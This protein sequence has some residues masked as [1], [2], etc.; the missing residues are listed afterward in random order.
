MQT[1]HDRSGLGFFLKK[2]LDCTTFV[3]VQTYLKL[4]GILGRI[5]FGSHISIFVM[6]AVL[7]MLRVHCKYLSSMPKCVI[8]E[9]CYLPSKACKCPFILVYIL[10]PH[11]ELKRS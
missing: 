6:C 1:P 10:L 5:K 8:F 4:L 7:S 9:S 11:V 2:N 3:H